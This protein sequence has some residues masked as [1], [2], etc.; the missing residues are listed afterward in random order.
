[1]EHPLEEWCFTSWEHQCQCASKLK[2]LTKDTLSRFFL[3]FAARLIYKQRAGGCLRILFNH[4]NALAEIPTQTPHSGLCNY[5]FAV[6]VGIDI[7][8]RSLLLASVAWLL[9]WSGVLYLSKSEP[10][11]KCLYRCVSKLKRQKRV[12][13][14]YRNALPLKKTK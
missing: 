1:M 5:T 3:S 14:A 10:K 4:L 7:I 11:Q 6:S 8:C 12:K 2:Q 9:H 13:C